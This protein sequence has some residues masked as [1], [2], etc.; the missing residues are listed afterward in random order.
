MGYTKEVIIPSIAK[1]ILITLDIFIAGA[2]FGAGL[3]YGVL[4][5]IGVF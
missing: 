4:Y 5:I 3:A 1:I 2:I